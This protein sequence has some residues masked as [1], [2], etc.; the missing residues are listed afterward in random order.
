MCSAA[1]FDI[2]ALVLRIFL[3]FFE[4][5]IQHA[6]SYI[7]F[8]SIRQR[9][10]RALQGKTIY[11]GSQFSRA[12]KACTHLLIKAPSVLT[13]SFQG[14]SILSFDYLLE[15]AH[16]FCRGFFSFSK[17]RPVLSDLHLWFVCIKKTNTEM[18]V[19]MIYFS[20][21]GENTNVTSTIMAQIQK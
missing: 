8:H 17:S 10:V 19:W 18:N 1:S 15:E 7:S 14:I 2:S 6:C 3:S 16:L 9:E 11:R 5:I 21:H 12:S 13:A 20:C 4:P